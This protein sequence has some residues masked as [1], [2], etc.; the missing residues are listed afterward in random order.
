M[1]N[2]NLGRYLA[3]W[4]IAADVLAKERIA[5]LRAMTDADTQRA[6]A[7]IFA[8]TSP[9]STIADE[10]TNGLIEQQRLFRL[11]R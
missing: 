9:V 2:P 8:S 7:E 5:R 3:A 1:E 10:S 11:L 4:E 6:I